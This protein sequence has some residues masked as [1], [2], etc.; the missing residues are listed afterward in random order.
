MPYRK[1]NIIGDVNLDEGIYLEMDTQGE[2]LAKLLHK[3]FSI[4]RNN[5]ISNRLWNVAICGKNEGRV[6]TQWL[7]QMPDEVW[8]I[9]KEGILKCL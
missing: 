7:E 8:E 5:S 3:R 4:E 9:V 6:D 1:L 2:D